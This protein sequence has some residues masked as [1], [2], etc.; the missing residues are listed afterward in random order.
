MN[1]RDRVRL[2]RGVADLIERR[3]YELDVATTLNVGKNRLES[4]GDIQ[5]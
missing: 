3:I 1:W 5:E 2:V 4:L